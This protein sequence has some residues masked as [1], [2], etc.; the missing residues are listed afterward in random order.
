MQSCNTCGCTKPL[1]EFHLR[2]DSGKRRPQCKSCRAD[3]E[4]ARRYGTSLRQVEDLR[5]KQKSRCAI[6]EIHEDDINHE[7]FK[8]NP[9]VIDHDHATG[10][11]RGLLCSKCNLI[12]GN[13]NDSVKTLK[14]AI[15]YLGQSW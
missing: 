8:H 5:V 13:A 2:R 6:C 10:K 15:R 9:L 11:V 3:I 4:V 1:G 14:A 12:L 7:A